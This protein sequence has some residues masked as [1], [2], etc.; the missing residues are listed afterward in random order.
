[1]SSPFGTTEIL[2]TDTE[3]AAA[4]AAENEALTDLEHELTLIAWGILIGFG[5]LT[6]WKAYRQTSKISREKRYR[7][8]YFW[9]VW[10]DYVSIM[11]FGVLAWI[12]NQNHIKPQL[13]SPVFFLSFIFYFC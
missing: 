10:M 6:G 4:A 8:P 1:M 7:S 13:V 11:L 9:W 5:Y 2:M 12:L 3:A